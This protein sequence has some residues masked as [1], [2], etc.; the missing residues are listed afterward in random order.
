MLHDYFFAKSL[1]A[2][3]PVVCWRFVT[4]AGTMNKLDTRGAGIPGRAG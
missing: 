1:D 3:V 2:C 4:S